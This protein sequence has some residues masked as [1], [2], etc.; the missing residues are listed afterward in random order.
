[1]SNNVL[2]NSVDHRALRV[3]AGH[4]AALGDDVMAAPTFPGEFRNAQAHYP[5]VFG[6]DAA[7]GFHPLVLFGLQEGAN[8]FLEG[9]RWDAA[10]IPL[11]V[12]RQ[13]FLIGISGEQRLIHVDLDHPRVRGG[14][15]EALFH[16]YGGATGIPG[17]DQVDPARPARRH[18]RHAG[19]HPGAV[20]ARA[21]GVLRPGRPAR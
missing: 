13:P 21:A 18:R 12:Q 20:A 16:D 17:A 8:L 2:L 4:G 11:S 19:L 15:G 7:G 5:I 10:Y 3:D 6:R 1:M 14:T 9:E